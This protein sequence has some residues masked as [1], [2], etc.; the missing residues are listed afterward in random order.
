MT[1]APT[2][3]TTTTM[4]TKNTDKLRALVQRHIAADQVI[5]GA[6]WDPDLN[7]GCFI[8]CLN[9]SSNPQDAEREYGLPIIVQRIAETIFEGLPL[10][11]ARSFFA[12]L[13]DAIGCDGKDL[14]KVC[15]QF[16]ATELRALPPQPYKIQIV[17]DSV[18]NGMEKLVR[19]EEWLCAAA[20]TAWRDAYAAADYAY[21]AT[22]AAYAYA[23]AAYSADTAWR[24]V[25]ATAVVDAADAAATW[26]AAAGGL[27]RF[28][29]RR[30]QR[31]TLLRLIAEAERAE[32]GQ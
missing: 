26:A 30:R 12:A 28:Q 3:I 2:T 4:L 16:L 29:A 1:E 8:G 7:R 21:A 9:H 14:S 27:S 17:I 23:A 18:I 20:D 6:Y 19:G 22:A 10:G 25:Y 15:W 24:D 31:D 32:E 5:Q 13:P 11:E